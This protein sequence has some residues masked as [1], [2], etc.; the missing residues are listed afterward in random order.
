MTDTGQ[1]RKSTPSRAADAHKVRQGSNIARYAKASRLGYGT[2]QSPGSKSVEQGQAP[3]AGS[4]FEAQ[5]HLGD[6]GASSDRSPNQG[7]RSSNLAIDLSSGHA[8]WWHCVSA[9]SITAASS[10]SAPS[11]SNRRRTDPEPDM[12]RL[13]IRKSVAIN[14]VLGARNR[15]GI[16]VHLRRRGFPAGGVVGDCQLLL[17]STLQ[18]SCWLRSGETR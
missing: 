11:S 18:S 8:T 9:M 7:A 2:P 1:K 6:S 13:D 15:S 5:R 17:L 12:Y 4:T 16:E 14:H 10:Q 3:W